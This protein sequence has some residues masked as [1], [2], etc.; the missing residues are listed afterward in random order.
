[1]LR[2]KNHIK[3][4]KKR[5]SSP[6]KILKAHTTSVRIPRILFMVQKKKKKSKF[7]FRTTVNY[8][9]TVYEALSR[10]SSC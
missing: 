6:L 1:M 7:T 4:K 3:K 2:P 9:S 5:M 10:K 8:S